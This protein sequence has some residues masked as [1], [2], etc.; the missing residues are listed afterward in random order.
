GL[1]ILLEPG[2]HRPLAGTI[3][4]HRVQTN[5]MNIAV[6]EGVITLA[7]RR[8]PAEFAQR[9]KAENGQVG[10]GL[11][12]GKSR[13]GFVIANGRPGDGSAEDF[14]IHIKYAALILEVRAAAIGIIS[15]Q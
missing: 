9:R 14:W 13:I 8:D 10:H 7:A 6:V 3:R 5:E 11:K 2:T 1:Q 15:E 12:I 4:R